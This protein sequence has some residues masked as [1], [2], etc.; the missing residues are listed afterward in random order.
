MNT[1]LFGIILAYPLINQFRWFTLVHERGLATEDTIPPSHSLF[2]SI[3]EQQVYSSPLAKTQII[4]FYSF[5]IISIT[6]PELRNF[7]IP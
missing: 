4:Y 7:T 6:F 2:I 5:L 3:T 1:F